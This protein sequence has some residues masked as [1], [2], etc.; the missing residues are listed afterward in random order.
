MQ[1]NGCYTEGRHKIRQ[2]S[3]KWDYK[4]SDRGEHEM[5]RF[6]RKRKKA[7]KKQPSSL[8][9]GTR[10]QKNQCEFSASRGIAT[11]AQKNQCDFSAY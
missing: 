2:V 10:A 5:L 4:V 7:Q 1:F 6:C 8:G 3:V 9:V 11:K